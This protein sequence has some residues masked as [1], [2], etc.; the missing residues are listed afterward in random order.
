MG[1]IFQKPQFS[2]DWLESWRAFAYEVTKFNH[3][4]F[5]V[6]I[7]QKVNT[8]QK[9]NTGQISK[10]LNFNPINLKFEE[11]LHIRSLD[12]ATY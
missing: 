9:L 8:D 5:G 1:Q 4:N 3:I 7:G 2:S 12:S 10:I 6:N 11:H